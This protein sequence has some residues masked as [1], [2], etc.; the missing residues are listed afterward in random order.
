[1][2]TPTGFYRRDDKTHPITPRKSKRGYNAS[3]RVRV[4]HVSKYA[5][6]SLE[7][8]RRPHEGRSPV[9]QGTDEG[10]KAPLA[11]SPGEWA[12]NMNRLDGLLG[13]RALKDVP[14]RESLKSKGLGKRDHA[15]LVGVE[16][17]RLLHVHDAT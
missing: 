5:G 4:P 6:L 8:A 17:L 2:S 15:V 13:V 7:E 12:A 16:D 14:R 9:A 3:A 1:L 11:G 10:L